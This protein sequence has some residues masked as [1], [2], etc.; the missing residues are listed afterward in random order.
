MYDYILGQITNNYQNKKGCFLVLESNKIGYLIETNP[1]ILANLPKENKE[2]KIYTILIHKED[3]MSLFGFLKREDRD[4]FKIL[5]SVSGVGPKMAL[6]LID[7]FETANLISLVIKGEYKELTRAK[8]VGDKLAQKIIIELKDKLINLDTIQTINSSKDLIPDN[9]QH[10]QDAH[11]VLISLGYTKEEI[12]NAFLQ[13]K[14]TIKKM[15]NAE[16]ILKESL[17]ILSL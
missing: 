5:T 15:D 8:G 7:E 9:T 10:M 12:N 13:A 3:S 16:N 6:T 1:R 2:Q 14:S 17:K 11:S 4:I